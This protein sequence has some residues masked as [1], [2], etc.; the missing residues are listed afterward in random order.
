[1]CLYS[2]DKVSIFSIYNKL[3][4]DIFLA[5]IQINNIQA[6]DRNPLLRDTQAIHFFFVDLK[7]LNR[8]GK[9]F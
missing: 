7:L 3:D 1:M 5:C 4:F 9:M 2:F 8:I 6:L